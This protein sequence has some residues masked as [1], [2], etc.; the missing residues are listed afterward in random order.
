MLISVPNDTEIKVEI[1]PTIADPIPATCPSGCI[2]RLFKLPNKIP[3]QKIIIARSL[4]NNPSIIIFDEATNALDS[5]SEKKLLKNIKKYFS[6]LTL[7]FVTHRLNSLKKCDKIVFLEHT[8][9][10]A[11]GS[12]KNLLKNNSSFNNLIKANN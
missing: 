7:I 11:V 2:A 12:F 4:Y 5:I 9:V 1:A 10:K 6:N 3:K 8:K